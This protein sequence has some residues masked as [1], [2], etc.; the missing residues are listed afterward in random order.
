[1]RNLGNLR[2][3]LLGWLAVL[4]GVLPFGARLS[5][6]HPC[7]AR[8]V[9]ARRNRYER[10]AVVGLTS[11]VSWRTFAICAVLSALPL[12][13]AAQ[14]RI[15]DGNIP[16]LY[17]SR[18][19]VRAPDHRLAAILSKDYRNA[20]DEFTRHDLLQQ[21]KPV[22][23]DRLNQARQTTQVYM[24]IGDQLGNY[25]FDRSAFPTDMSENTYIRFDNG[26]EV[27]Y[28]NADQFG[29][30][31]VP[32]EEARSLAGALRSSRAVTFRME[33]GV[34]RATEDWDRKIV[35]MRVDKIV[36]SLKNKRLIV[37]HEIQSQTLDP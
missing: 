24:L 19:A 4:A 20:E 17:E 14:T 10:G 35:Y 2:A 13:A 33:G 28:D 27:R 18:A 26:Y 29:F 23:E 25:D 22:I 34:A 37:E 6:D 12:S 15:T 3:H 16:F 32:P 31:P 1:M 36:L 9:G 30:V 11:A 8:C 5:V 21:I 7:A